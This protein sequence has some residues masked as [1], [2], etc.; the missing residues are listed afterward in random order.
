MS[1]KKSLTALATLLAVS[2]LASPAYATGFTDIGQDIRLHDDDEFSLELDGYL[3]VRGEILHNLDLD[4]GASPSGQVLFPVPIDDPQ[5]QTLYETDMRV[6]TDLAIY[7]PG[8]TV[9]LKLR[10]D[11][12]DNLALGSTPDGAPSASTT[13]RALENAIHVRR[14]YG[15]VLTPIGILAAGRMGNQWG[16]G[17]LANGGDCADCDSGDA[18]DRIAFV[19]PLAGHLWAAS[20]DL[21]SSGPQIPR[22]SGFRPIDITPVDDVRTVTFA[23]MNWLGEE[24]RLRRHRAGRTTFEYGAYVSH[25]W[26]DGDI[27]ATYVPTASAITLTPQQVM[28]RGFQATAVD[29]W[30]RVQGP[31]FRIELEAAYLHG[32]VAQSSLVP[33]VLLRDGVTSNQFG[34]ALESDFLDP[35]GPFTFGLAAGLASG[36]P[37]PGFGAYP[38][39]GQSYGQ[40]GDIEAPQANIPYDNTIDNFRFHPDYRID[41]I[42]FREI[43]GTVTDAFYFRPHARYRA[44]DE[45]FGRLD[46]MLYAVSS[47]AMEPTSTPGNDRPLGL[48]LDPS[49][50]YQS[51]EGFAVALDYA[52]LVPFSGLDNPVMGLRAQPA[53][54]ARLRLMYGF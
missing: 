41:R 31:E 49:L 27:P 46:F 4:R 42:L 16:L 9:A 14:A 1:T 32:S 18:Q 21:T 51:R 22:R 30:L 36:D 40:P 47:F 13:Q 3:R 29:L 11:T 17:M 15:E 24:P 44:F 7:A 54:L 26:Q 5:A 48:E 53:Q 33:G 20:F 23:V 37:A 38:R 12:L 39:L 19:T 6:R 28:P 10:L 43:I 52:F 45:P 2:S 34:A 35:N 8:G 25:R 50:Y